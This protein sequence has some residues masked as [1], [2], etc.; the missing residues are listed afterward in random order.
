MRAACGQH[1]T[2][3]PGS[4]CY[5]RVAAPKVGENGFLT[6]MADEGR[7]LDGLPTLDSRNSSQ[8]RIRPTA[9]IAS[10]AVILVA[11]IW[12]P[13]LWLTRLE[14]GPTEAR[15]GEPD[16]SDNG[17][18]P[19]VPVRLRD[20]E[21]DY[22]APANIFRRIGSGV[23]TNSK[24]QGVVVFVA[25]VGATLLATAIV[26][27]VD[28]WTDTPQ[29]AYFSDQSLS[30]SSTVGAWFA[31]IPLS[32]RGPYSGR[33][34]T[35]VADDCQKLISPSESP[36]KWQN[37]ADAE[38]T[39]YWIARKPTVVDDSVYGNVELIGPNDQFTIDGYI[40]NPDASRSV[41][42]D[43]AGFRLVEFA[44]FDHTDLC[45]GVLDRGKLYP[46]PP[47]VGGGELETLQWFSSLAIDPPMTLGPIF[48]QEGA[49]HA[50]FTTG[51]ALS[52]GSL[53]FELGPGESVRFY[54]KLRISS[55][56]H[57]V[58]QPILKTRIG[59]AVKILDGEEIVLRVAMVTDLGRTHL[60]VGSSATAPPQHNPRPR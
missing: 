42:I 45:F 21:P 44:P 12:R 10:C 19:L 1:S 9:V 7:R 34:V 57:F 27:A 49:S 55:P 37:D 46:S 32:S 13:R 2:G 52:S 50:Q 3:R 53:A 31:D 59:G 26:R 60:G 40:Y 28:G 56:G 4:G 16:G 48:T 29:Y 54:A 8:R 14:E 38:R 23:A 15:D 25:G 58:V 6:G 51:T 41:V 30:H 18:L 47:V 22:I 5:S 39:T 33:F 36:E 43:A 20:V 17:S 11:L 35:L 24:R